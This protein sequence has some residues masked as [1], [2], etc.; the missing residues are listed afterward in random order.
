MNIINKYFEKV[1]IITCKE[2]TNRHDLVFKQL[3]KFNIQNYEFIISIDHERL[4]SNSMISTQEM[5][6]IISHI[7]C[8]FLSKL[9]KLNNICIFEDDFLL[10]NNYEE[11]MEDFMKNL[12]SD[13]SYLHLGVP[14]WTYNFS[15]PEF[16]IVNNFVRHLKFAPASH[17]IGLNSKCFDH[18]LSTFT[19]F[20]MPVDH[21]YHKKVYSQNFIGYIPNESL[22]DA[23]SIPHEK[24][25]SNIKNFD[26]NNY[27]NSKIRQSTNVP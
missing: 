24:Y 12:P 6:L 23:K 2:D 9:N 13:W 17:F 3:Q 20:D 14:S 25:H 26:K 21:M 1:Y 4:I 22:C 18:I 27:I 11:K 16:T 10:L 15:E 7:N 8:V 19:N 5:S